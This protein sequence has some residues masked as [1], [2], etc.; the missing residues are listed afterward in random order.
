MTVYSRVLDTLLEWEVGAKPRGKEAIIAWGLSFLF[1]IP[2]PQ[3]TG[4]DYRPVESYPSSPA[5]TWLGESH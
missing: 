1:I 4:S 2:S 5:P 3:V